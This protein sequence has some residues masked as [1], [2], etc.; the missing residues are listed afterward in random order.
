[1]QHCN[2][3]NIKTILRDLLTIRGVWTVLGMN[4]KRNVTVNYHV[5]NGGV[6]PG[7][8]IGLSGP[9]CSGQTWS[10][11]R[12]QTYFS[13]VKKKNIFMTVCKKE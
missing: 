6:G 5:N 13:S 11:G 1:M 3:L 9:V 7:L 2:N 10:S 12:Y 4:S 8:A